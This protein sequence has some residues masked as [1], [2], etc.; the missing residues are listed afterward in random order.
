[1]QVNTPDFMAD[2]DMQFLIAIA[3]TLH[4][5]LNKFSINLPNG[6]MLTNI[7]NTEMRFVGIDQIKFA[8]DQLMKEADDS[9]WCLVMPTNVGTAR[10]KIG[11]IFAIPVYIDP[12]IPKGNFLIQEEVAK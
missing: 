4:E 3:N 2:E 9:K 5:R 10:Q 7:N 11:E 8:L 1:M 6:A 12:A